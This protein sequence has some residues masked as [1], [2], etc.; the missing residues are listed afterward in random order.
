MYK[1]NGN[2]NEQTGKIKRKQRILALKSAI[3]TMKNLLEGFRW[4]WAH[5]EWYGR[6]LLKGLKG[7]FEQAKESVNFRNFYSLSLSL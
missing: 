3:T 5:S 2:I 1:Q 7:K 6:R 4:D